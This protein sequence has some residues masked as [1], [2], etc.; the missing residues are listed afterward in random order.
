VLSVFCARK[1]E[2]Q[3]PDAGAASSDAAPPE[4][5][6]EVALSADA[7]VAPSDAGSA[8]VAVVPVVPVVPILTVPAEPEP[9]VPPPS[10]AE[11]DARALGTVVV[12]ARYRAEDPQKV[13]IAIT[14]IDDSQIKQLG[15]TRNLNQIL[16]QLPSLNIQGYSG[17]NQTITIRGLGTNAGS[18]N[19]GLE[20]GVGVYI[21]GVYRP[22]TGTVITDMMDVESFQLL[23]GPQ[24]TLF[25][26]N[27]VAG[28]I[29]IKTTAP[30][31][32]RTV[33][34]EA[35]Y[36]N[37]NYMRAFFSFSNPITDTLSLRVGYQRTQRDGLIYNTT[38]K[39]HWDDLNNDAVKAD[40]YWRPSDKFKNR[41]IGDYSMQKCDCGFQVVRQALPTTKADGSMVR[42][43]YEKSQSI[44]YKAP[45]PIKPFDRKTDIN[46]SQFDRMPSWGIQNN[47]DY[48]FDNDLTLT[49]ISAYRN[50]KWLPNFDGDQF[51][52]D[53]QDQGIVVTHQQQFSQELRIASPGDQLVDYTAGLYYFWQEMDDDQYTNYATKAS[54]WLLGPN[55]DPRIL[56]GLH[57]YRHVVPATNSYAA[58]GQATYNP[59]KVLHLTGGVRFTFEHK[60]GLYDAEPQGDYTPLS[61]FPADQQAS[62]A[63]TR[64][65]YA[66]T[67]RYKDSNNTH[68]FSGTANV[69]YD[70][71]RDIH[72]YTTYSRGYKSPGI[73]LV[74]KDVGVDV[75]VKPEVV[76]SFEGGFKTSFFDSRLEVN[77]IFFWVIDRNYQTNYVNRDVTP[78][79]SYITNAGNLISRGFELDVRLWP[80]KGVRGSASLTYNKATYDDYTNAPAQYMYS[81]LVTQ[82]L[83]GKQAAG[84]PKWAAG[85]MLQYYTPIAG[86]K[87]REIEAYVGGDW[88]YRSSFLAAVNLDP[89]SEIPA[90]NLVGLSGGFRHS[91]S[92]WDVQLWVRNLLDKNYYGTTSVSATHGITLA[93]L[94][95]PRTFGATVRGKF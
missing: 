80:V 40:L 24:G 12:T 14:S 10:S 19:D 60:T 18:T 29:D 84:A 4:A 44:G 38:Y 1:V 68:N 30:T 20:Q 34:A 57:S 66:P 43:F 89:Y 3:A 26:K 91:R 77:P 83:S 7:G 71:T 31:L 28:A 41:L 13:P 69:A 86:A 25:G 8:D 64:D 94:G 46:D 11:N 81:Y 2:A 93:S 27:T 87:D 70:I 90:Y 51:G 53:I 36:G 42:G 67:E 17:R 73:N 58:F 63:A 62:V 15:G 79:R 56:N 33:R 23:R 32:E 22:R 47:A 78:A 39:E 9:A 45:N 92:Y 75:F 61:E 35:T 49:S 95:E 76:D 50:W 21:D 6:A 48:R 85:A 82:D 16:G 5:P 52:A 72:V 37:F 55:S 74:S 54:Q 65:S 88:S 59:W